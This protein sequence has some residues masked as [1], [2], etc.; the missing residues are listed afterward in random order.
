MTTPVILAVTATP[1]AGLLIEWSSGEILL[2]EI[3]AQIECFPALH[4][5]RDGERFA[6]AKPGVDGRGLSWGDGAE[7][8]ADLLYW[9]GK[10]QAP[11]DEQRLRLAGYVQI[12]RSGGALADE[13]VSTVEALRHPGGE[14]ISAELCGLLLDLLRGKTKAGKR[15][16]VSATVIRE[17]FQR[18]YERMK[19]DDFAKGQPVWEETLSSASFLAGHIPR[20]SDGQQP[21]NPAVKRYV[22]VANSLAAAWRLSLP[23]VCDYISGRKKHKSQGR[24]ST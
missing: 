13:L 14:P 19:V 24:K 8:S 17:S 10:E 6:R 7:I 15:V 1:P 21:S 9:L 5:L 12:Y 11:I 22:A 20:L 16:P 23:T 3:G 2:I 4:V 18:M